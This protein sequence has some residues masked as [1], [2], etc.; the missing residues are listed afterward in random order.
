MTDADQQHLDD[1][2]DDLENQHGEEGAEIDLVFLDILGNVVKN[3]PGPMECNGDGLV[4]HENDKISSALPFRESVC[5][6][7]IFII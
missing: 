7:F 3:L 1:Y 6:I 2:L 5:N 4:K